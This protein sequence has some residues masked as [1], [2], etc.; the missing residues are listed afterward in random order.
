MSLKMPLNSEQLEGKHKIERFINS[1]DKFFL[2]EG[3][4]GTGKT[5]LITKIFENPSY[6][7]KKIVFSATTNKAV[8]VLETYCA[9]HREHIAF[10]TIQKLLKIQRKINEDGKEIF[11][12]FEELNQ[13]ISCK[14]K[15]S[16]HAFDIIIIDEVSMISSDVLQR[17]EF[18][19]PKIKGK[20]ILLGDRNQLPPINETISKVFNK[21]Y[22]GQ[23]HKLTI[24]ERFKN[25]IVKYSNSIIQQTKIKKKDLNP[26]AVEFGKHYE[27]WIQSYISNMKSSIILTYT[28]KARSKFNKH[29]RSILFPDTYQRFS[30]NEKII[31]NNYY[32]TENSKFFSSQINTIYSIDTEVYEFSSLPIESLLNLKIPLKQL[33]KKSKSKVGDETCP[34]CFDEIDELE[35]TNCGH[36]F[37]SL[38]IKT[39]L[40]QH[41]CCPLCR[42]DI[43]N[44]TLEI[45]NFSELSRIIMELKDKLNDIKLTVWKIV[46]DDSNGEPIIVIS[47]K[48]LT[49]YKE[50]CSYIEEKLLYIKKIISKRSDK[51]NNILLIR[52]WEFYYNEYLDIIADIDY[53]YAITVHKSQGS[54]YEN[55]YIDI[56]NIIKYNNTDTKE[57]VY[58]S[59]T[60]ASNK[61]F[62]L[63]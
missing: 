12:Y 59:V 49:E 1:N 19:A 53:G 22:K 33:V 50:V 47:D 14:D 61:L 24:V 52:L 17:L 28:N 45:K 58:T 13:E 20:I 38:C 3:V 11:S 27:N 10:L 40:K 63:T 51:F 46:L 54:T 18:L 62:V 48:S 36:L 7:H 56:Q 39:W 25:D 32:K 6:N 60:R 8:S 5:T 34:I 31:F 23:Y 41:N 57:C 37:C 35:Q 2:L 44:D 21:K 55:V 9:I 16:I 43:S 15:K 30:V 29:I 42:C 4:A 26:L